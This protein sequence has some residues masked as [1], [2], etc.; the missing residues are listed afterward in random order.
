MADEHRRIDDA[1]QVLK[2]FEADLLRV[3]REGHTGRSRPEEVNRR[4][5]TLA[6][7]FHLTFHRIHERLERR[8]LSF[9]QENRMRGL[10]RH[11]LW[12]YRKARVE[13]FFVRKLRLEDDL[14]QRD[15]LP[16]TTAG[17]SEG[18]TAMDNMTV[19]NV[20]G[21]IIDLTLREKQSDQLSAWVAA[22]IAARKKSS[23][24][25]CGAG[26]AGGAC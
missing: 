19:R 11:C 20:G 12:L 17:T 10:R 8:D 2:Q 5:V 18:R 6:R 14:R 13:D 25:C 4:L 16:A 23:A 7:E 22:R 24:A 9:D 15:M 26:A 3:I 1:A 21:C